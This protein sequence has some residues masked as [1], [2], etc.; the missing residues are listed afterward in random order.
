[1]HSFILII[2]TAFLVNNAPKK[3]VDCSNLGNF[4]DKEKGVSFNFS[5]IEKQVWATEN[6]KSK[7]GIKNTNKLDSEEIYGHYYNFNGASKA[8]PDGWRLPTTEDWEQL[9]D[10]VGGISIAGKELKSKGTSAT[11][12]YWREYKNF[13]GK[14]SH[15]FEAQPAGFYDHIGGNFLNVGEYGYYW[16]AS[17]INSSKAFVVTFNYFSD[18]VV[19]N[20][21]PIDNYYSVRCIKE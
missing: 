16:T 11:D 1:M 2:F 10:N 17:S 13:T 14:N 12:G 15:C 5:K 20:E 8:C 19:F 4:T 6:L 7:Y 9:I 21:Y 18:K 3:T